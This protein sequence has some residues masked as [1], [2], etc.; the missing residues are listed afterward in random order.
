MRFLKL[1][2]DVVKELDGDVQP[3]KPKVVDYITKNQALI[4]ESVEAE[5]LE[6]FHDTASAGE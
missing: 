4:T 5:D 3:V 2:E 1:L 6:D